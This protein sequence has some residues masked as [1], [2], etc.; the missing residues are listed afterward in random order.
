M[1]AD[2][3]LGK[4]TAVP[5]GIWNWSRGVASWAPPVLTLAALAAVGWWGSRNDWQLPAFLRSGGE[6]AQ[7]QDADADQAIRVRTTPPGAESASSNIP[8]AGE[9]KWIELPSADA[10]RKLGLRLAPVQERSLTQYV[11]ANGMVDYEPA[12]YARLTSRASGTIWR[13]FK[14]I[15]DPIQKGEVL[16]L[17]EAAEVGRA[18]ADFLQGLALFRQRST[19]WKQL[20]PA[21][22]T[23]AVPDRT[24]IDAEFALRQA[25]IQLAG[26]HQA[27]VNLGFPLRLKEVEKLSDEELPRYLRLLGLPPAFAK[28][29]DSETLTANLLPLTA[30]FDGQVVERNAATGEVVDLNSRPQILFVVADL[31]QVHID[32]D[33]NP[34]DIALVHVGQPVSFRPNDGTPEASARVSHLSPEVDAKTRRVRVH[35]QAANQDRSLRPNAFG[36]GRIL[37]GQRPRALVVPGEAL[38]TDGGTSLVFVRASETAFEARE[39]RPG[40]RQGDLVEVSGVRPGEEVVTTGS[41]VLRSELHKDRIAGGD[42]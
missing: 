1:A 6:A 27:L 3:T 24:V 20:R 30:P 33:V 28:Q 16:A 8:Q 34:E 40:L 23:G 26:A 39:V 17:I 12:A 14:E 7:A 19:V 18:K 29:L 2:G 21:E 32:L 42:D 13:V 11:T 5:R 41:F 38:Q 36:T 25:R 31:R 37:V 9:R 35:A 4:E 22:R 15:G 10:V